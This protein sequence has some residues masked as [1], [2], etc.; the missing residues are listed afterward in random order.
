[1]CIPV[2]RSI[3]L[4]RVA[5]SETIASRSALSA[6]TV[7]EYPA[8]AWTPPGASARLLGRDLSVG[9]ETPRFAVGVPAHTRPE[10]LVEA[11]VVCRARHSRPD[12]RQTTGDQ[13]HDYSS[14]GAARQPA[15]PRSEISTGIHG[16]VPSI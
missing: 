11:V 15:P 12:D 10:Q 14:S 2:G 1:M 9:R 3:P 5:A 16:K 4:S 6:D 7:L 13:H 8:S